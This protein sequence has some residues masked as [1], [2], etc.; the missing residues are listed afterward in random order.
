MRKWA[1]LVIVLAIGAGAFFYYH[2]IKQ[3]KPIKNVMLITIDTLRAD[4]LGCYGY[5][6]AQTPHID[7]W[8]Q[9]GV[10]F[11]NATAAVPLTLPSHSTI[12]TGAYPL[13]HGVRDNGGFFFG[14][15]MNTPSRTMKNARG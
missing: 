8:A 2:H 7:E 11:W 9:K 10:Q 15:K 6:R 5:A 4:H 12:M 14:N 3:H 13:A 1:I